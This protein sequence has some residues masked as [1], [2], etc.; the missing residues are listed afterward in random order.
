[1]LY[2][3]LADLVHRGVDTAGD[4]TGF[5]DPTPSFPSV[6]V[7]LDCIVGKSVYF[8]QM[9]TVSLPASEQDCACT[10]LNDALCRLEA[11]VIQAMFDK[12][13][14]CIVEKDRTAMF[15][16]FIASSR[17]SSLM[18]TLDMLVEPA[19]SR[20]RGSAAFF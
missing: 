5:W 19:I 20:K 6:E 16:R 1:M 11:A 12:V 18:N 7:L 13:V 9:R 10:F 14:F 3:R 17:C 4:R 2:E 15:R 8:R